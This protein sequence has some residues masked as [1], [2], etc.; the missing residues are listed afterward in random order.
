[1]TLPII[2]EYLSRAFTDRFAEYSGRA[3]N[4]DLINMDLVQQ[5]IDKLKRGKAAGLD[6]L[7][8]EHIAFAH[9]IICFHL[10]CL[11]TLFRILF[12]CSMVPD[13]FGKGIIIPLLNKKTVL[14]Q[15]NRAM[16][17][18]FFSV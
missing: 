7:M 10:T 14:S 9:P 18:L 3:I 8:A 17:Q 12:A 6:G 1:M 11:L 15:G 5:C 16:P 2:F 4:L 13:D